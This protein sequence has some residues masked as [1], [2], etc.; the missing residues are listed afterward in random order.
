MAYEI[1]LLFVCVSALIFALC[2]SVP[3][4]VLCG[5]CRIKGNQSS[6]NFLFFVPSQHRSIRN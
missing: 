5:P 6:M 1:T 3:L 2:V 4:S